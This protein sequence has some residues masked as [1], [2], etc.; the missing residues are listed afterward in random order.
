MNAR[1]AILTL[2]LFAALPVQA[3]TLSTA[4]D[5]ALQQLLE[6][7]K[8]THSSAILVLQDG[9]EIGHYY[10]DNKAPGPIELMSVTSRWWLWGSASYSIKA[11][12]SRSISRWRTSIPS[13]SRV[14]RRTLP[15]ACC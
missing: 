2:A 1:L 9:R 7:G 8:Q 3:G 13:E 11:G 4:A 12:S 6:R 5:S 15:F 10:P 14:A